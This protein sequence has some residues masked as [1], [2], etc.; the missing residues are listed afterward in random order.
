MRIILASGSPRRVEL[1]KQF[2]NAID[3]IPS[4]I[5]E[6]ISSIDQPKQAVMALA[7]EKGMQVALK[8]PDAL[9]IASDTVVYKDVILGKPEDYEDAKRMLKLLNNATH[10]VFTGIA[11]IC[12]DRGLKIVDYERTGV[13][14]NELSDNMI[15]DY[16][17]TGE[18]FDK[19][20]AYGIQGHGALLVNGIEGDFFNVMGLPLSKLNTMLIQHY[21]LN[22]MKRGD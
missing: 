15:C 8:Y 14:F 2:V 12:L 3:I 17:D 18:P 7:Y 11:L 6:K 4:S 21:N 9:V 13:T 5:E 10:D 20:G 19:A 1:L 16:L 22:L